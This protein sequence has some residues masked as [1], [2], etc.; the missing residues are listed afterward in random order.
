PA[1]HVQSA[2]AVGETGRSLVAVE[3]G[4]GHGGPL[5]R[6]AVRGLV[7]SPPQAEPMSKHAIAK[8][9]MGAC[10]AALDQY[11]HH[12]TVARSTSSP[13]GLSEAERL[14]RAGFASQ[15]SGKPWSPQAHNAFEMLR[16][17]ELS[18]EVLDFHETD[19]PAY[20]RFGYLCL[21]LLV[22]L[23]ERRVIEDEDD[24]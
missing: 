5:G 21:G 15:V 8:V 4:S 24:M 2:G 6:S 11:P 10:S 14:G 16:V 13:P 17:S 20:A 23:Q 3:R 9:V 1:R 22:G 18:Q 19:A 12:A 7:R